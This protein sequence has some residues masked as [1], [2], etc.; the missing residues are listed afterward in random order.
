L[1]APEIY[2]YGFEWTGNYI[3]YDKEALHRPRKE[4]TFLSEKILIQR[5]ASKLICAFDNEQ[6]YT[7]NSINNLVLINPEFSLKYIIALLNSK[8]I[9]YYYRKQFSFDAGFT[10]TVTKENLDIRQFSLNIRN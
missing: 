2:R 8:L 10:I 1:E 6:Y 3:N 5:V 9:N 7:F 4:E